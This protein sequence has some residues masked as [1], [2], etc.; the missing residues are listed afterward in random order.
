MNASR[1]DFRPA[2][3]A[4]LLVAVL[5]YV[6][7][8]TS[9]PP[10]PS[11][12][13]APSQPASPATSSA[14]ATKQ[15]D[16]GAG[17]SAADPLAKLGNPAAVLVVSNEQEGY[18]EP[19]GC[20]PQQLGGLIRRYDLIERLHNRKWPT[21]LIDGGTLIK[22]PAGALGG[23]EQAKYKFDY[24]LKALNLMK[25]DAV[26]L[27]AQDLKIGVGEALG[28][29]DNNLTS[30]KTRIVAANVQPE[31]IFEKLF[32]TSVIATA[33]PVKLG[34]TAV[35]DPGTLQNLNDPEKDALLPSVKRPEDVLPGVL[36]ELESRSDFQ[37]LMVQGSPALARQLAEAYPGFDIVLATSTTPDPLEHEADRLNGGKTLLVTVGKRGK[38][39]GL[40][41]FYPNEPVKTRYLL[42]TLTKRYEALGTPMKR[43][44]EDE[45]RET[46][47]IAGTV[48]KF[49]RRDFV[50]GAPGAVFTGAETCEKCHPKTFEFWTGTKHSQAFESLLEDPKPNTQFDAE[51]ITCHTTGFE[52]NSGWRSNAATPHLAGNQCENCHGPGSKHAE[53]PT[54]AQFRKLIKVTAEQADK[55]LCIRCHDEDNSRNFSFAKYWKDIAHNGLDKYTDPQVRQG[56][57]PKTAEPR[58]KTDAP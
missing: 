1:I 58:S 41:G 35:T 37:V 2:A 44:I 21:A 15:A 40:V 24:A 54:N 13:S 34:I 5:V 43:L 56:I 23:F 9:T 17:S 42:E 16:A 55:N 26:A 8:T 50:N 19:C 25:Y 45:Y 4:A 49:V 6:G 11:T 47:K 3:S 12:S 29:L 57:T 7:C 20:S 38:Y 48:E 18:L 36:A 31:K 28:L 32:Q 33:G 39:V 22:D 30:G 51:C 10:P 46:L 14:A 52:Y 27:S 53:D